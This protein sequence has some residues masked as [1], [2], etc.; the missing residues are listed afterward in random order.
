MK[1]QHLEGSSDDFW[2]FQKANGDRSCGD[3]D[4]FSLETLFHDYNSET[5]QCKATK[6][7]LRKHDFRLMQH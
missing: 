2:I 1:L 4:M 7:K 3:E 6:V 5:L